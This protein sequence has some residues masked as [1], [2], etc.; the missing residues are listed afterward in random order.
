[1]TNIFQKEKLV[2]SISQ[3]PNL[4]RFLCRPKFESQRK[5]REMKNSGKN[6]VSCPYL[7]KTS[8]YQ[9]KRVNITFL[10][11]NFLNCESSN[12][13]YVVICQGCKEESTGE[14]EN[15]SSKTENRYS[16]A[17]YKTA[18]ISKIGS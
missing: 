12:L 1:M 5:Y 2:N 9:Y 10:L 7:L 4:G 11:K 16:Q 15:G 8:L 18:T 6:C 17:T 13:I 14:M 3:S